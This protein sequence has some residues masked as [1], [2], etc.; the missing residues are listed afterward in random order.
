MIPLAVRESRQ[1][2]Q[3]AAVLIQDGLRSIGVN[4][5]V[6]ILPDGDY[7]SKQN[8]NEL[9]LQI[10]DWHSW[11]EDPFY[12]MKFLSSCGSF[13][14]YARFCDKEYDKL[15]EEGIF[16]TDKTVRQTASSKAQKIFLDQAPWAPLWSADRT[17]VVRSCITGVVRDYTLVA[18]FDKLNGRN[19]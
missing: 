18:V 16:S 5:E 10:G 11:G 12:Q 7:A 17:V 2:D 15:I 14:N 8:A 1:D 19:C 9:P 4:V 6:Q 3:A 13:V